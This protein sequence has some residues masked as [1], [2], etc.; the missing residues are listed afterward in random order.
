[1]PPMA[2]EFQIMTGVDLL[3]SPAHN[4]GVLFDWYL[5]CSNGVFTH[6]FPRSQIANT[7]PPII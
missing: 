6:L 3:D 4:S 2:K 7:V 5:W 1:M